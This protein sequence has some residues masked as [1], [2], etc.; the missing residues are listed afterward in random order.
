MTGDLLTVLMGDE[1]AGRLERG[2]AE[3]LTFTYD[4]RYRRRPDPA[5]LSV[6]MPLAV[7]RHSGGAVSAWLWGLLPDDDRVLRRWAERFEVRARSPFDLLGTPVGRD[8]A[9]A[10]S[11]VGAAGADGAGAAGDDV[12]WLSDDQVADRLRQ[13][14]QDTTA[15][16]GADFTGRFSLAGAQAK[17]ALLRAG[18]RWG[19]PARRPGHHA[20]PQACHRRLRPARPQRAPVPAGRRRRARRGPHRG[21]RVRRP[22]RRRRRTL[23]PGDSAPARGCASIRRTSARASACTRRSSTRPRAVP[24]PPR[25]PPCSARSCPP[26]SPSAVVAL[27]PGPAVELGD[28]RHRRPRQELLAAARARPGTLRRSLRRRLGPA[29]RPRA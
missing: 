27:R 13:L 3:R 18:D 14:R 21:R 11:F 5:P 10:V 17:T 29:V 8:C 22:E 24:G 2:A 23:R 26:P 19:P 9:G 28:R 20:H 12:T 15:W 16:L 4:E 25:S 7:R 6:S 1:V